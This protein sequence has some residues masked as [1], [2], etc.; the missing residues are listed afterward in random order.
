VIGGFQT[1]FPGQLVQGIELFAVGFGHVQVQALGLVQPLLAPCGGFHQPAGVDVKGGG[2]AG[3]QY[4]WDAVDLL[5]ATVEVFEVV[6]HHVVPQ[7]FGFEI[8][9][10][11]RVDHGELAGEVRFDEQVLVRRL[12][13]LGYA[14][15]VGDGCRGRDGH[16]VTVAHTVF[17][18]ELAHRSPV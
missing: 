13:R 5:H 3:F 1:A 9:H 15:N 18:D 16:H 10:Q 4:R 2:V 17:G 11:G 14:D 8:A 7:A 6:D 12:D